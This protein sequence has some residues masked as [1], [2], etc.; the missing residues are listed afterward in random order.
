M[1]EEDLKGNVEKVKGEEA[2]KQ[3]EIVTGHGP[4]VEFKSDLPAKSFKRPRKSRK[5]STWRTW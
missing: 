5:K 2:L 1:K 3:G 4:R